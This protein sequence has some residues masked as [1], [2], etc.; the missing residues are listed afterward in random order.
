M[1]PSESFHADPQEMARP[2][3]NNWRFKEWGSLSPVHREDTPGMG[4]TL[5]KQTGFRKEVN[6]GT[7]DGSLV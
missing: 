3:I 7:C 5:R 4:G 1:R 2:M 6:A